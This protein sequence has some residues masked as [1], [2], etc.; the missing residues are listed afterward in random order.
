MSFDFDD[1]ERKSL[2]GTSIAAPS[3]MRGPENAE[4]ELRKAYNVLLEG[5]LPYFWQNRDIPG[6]VPAEAAAMYKHAYRCFRNDNRL[7][8]ERWARA[9]KHLSRAFSCEAKIAYLEA[10]STDLP[11]LVGAAPE[12]YDLR[13]QS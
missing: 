6:V 4:Y 13:T 2:P 11:F 7:A 9:S 8:A 3:I 12:D 10:R 1:S 5:T